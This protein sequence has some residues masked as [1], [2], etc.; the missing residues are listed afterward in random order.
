MFL[1]L[2]QG[3]VLYR[4]WFFPQNKNQCFLLDALAASDSL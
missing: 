2:L 3:P 1:L 4:H